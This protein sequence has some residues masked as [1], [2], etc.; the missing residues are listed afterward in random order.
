MVVQRSQTRD[1][2]GL[3]Q[4]HPPAQLSPGGCHRSLG[5][6][7]SLKPQAQVGGRCRNRASCSKSLLFFYITL[8]KAA[9]RSPSHCSNRGVNRRPQA[10]FTT[11]R[12][13]Y[14]GVGAALV[15]DCTSKWHTWVA[16][17]HCQA[18]RV[19]VRVPS[20][21]SLAVV[22]T[23][24]GCKHRLLHHYRV[25][26][27]NAQATLWARLCS[28]CLEGQPTLAMHPDAVHQVPVSRY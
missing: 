14:D 28:W 2:K 20:H 9:S 17:T 16:T 26:V 1:E 18:M 15:R 4:Q 12:L 24:T 19:T 27:D 11:K 6:C 8:Y 7:C 13:D 3:I 25:H 5:T 22:G 23:R 10:R 21:S